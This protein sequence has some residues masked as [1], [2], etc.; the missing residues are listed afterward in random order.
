[1][2]IVSGQVMGG[3]VSKL[4]RLALGD[5]QKSLC[6]CACL[7]ISMAVSADH[8]VEVIH[9]PAFTTSAFA[10]AV[11]INQE[12][13]L[14]PIERCPKLFSEVTRVCSGSVLKVS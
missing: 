6:C 11:G 8:I 14:W 5:L 7:A 1:M 4:I 12:N 9:N 2:L 10:K 3:Y 13:F